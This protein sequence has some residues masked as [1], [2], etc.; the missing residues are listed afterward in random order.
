MWDERDHL[1]IPGIFDEELPPVLAGAPTLVPVELPTDQMEQAIQNSEDVLYYDLDSHQI[2]D[3]KGHLYNKTNHEESDTNTSNNQERD[4]SN[5][6]Y[7]E[8]KTNFMNLTI[9]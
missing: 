1:V 3:D 8:G 9:R 2:C 6:F 5:R 7:T 4:E